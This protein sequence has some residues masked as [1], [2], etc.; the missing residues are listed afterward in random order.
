ML[1]LAF[2]AAIVSDLRRAEACSLAPPREF[3]VDAA[4]ADDITPPTITLIR[5]EVRRVDSGAC[6][7][8]DADCG[9]YGYVDISLEVAD[10][11]APLGE[12]G[13]E[14]RVLSGGGE[15]VRIR[16]GIEKTY[17]TGSLGFRFD[18]DSDLD[19]TVEITA[20]DLNGN[21]SEPVIVH[22]QDNKILACSAGRG[23]AAHANALLVVLAAL[24]AVRRRGGRERRGV[25]PRRA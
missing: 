22:A 8:G 14:M 18:F 10:D 21:P 5:H 12:L 9:S 1:P 19:V 4:Y 20:Y 23:R 15:H 16:S 25:L 2:L 7:D 24:I 3:A 13:Y 6:G 17:G 11:R